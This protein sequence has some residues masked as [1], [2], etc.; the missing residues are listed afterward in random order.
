ML[1]VTTRVAPDQL[2]E[3]GLLHLGIHLVQAAQPLLHAPLGDLAVA[4]AQATLPAG[5]ALLLAGV[6]AAGASV[7]VQAGVV[8]H[9]A[10]GGRCGD[11]SEKGDHE[12]GGRRMRKELR[13]L[14]PRCGLYGAAVLDAGKWTAGR[15]MLSGND[16]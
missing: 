3:R 9:L 11:G 13:L 1:P 2:S 6:V 4:G 10:V 7:T 15:F 5:A 12:R 8:G 14:A 16:L